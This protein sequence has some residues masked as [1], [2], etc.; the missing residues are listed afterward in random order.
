MSVAQFVL[1]RLDDEPILTKWAAAVSGS[2]RA[3][4]GMLELRR[5]AAVW[6]DHPDF[7]PAWRP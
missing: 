2:V 7:N 1:A 5:L 6:H 4:V 3:G